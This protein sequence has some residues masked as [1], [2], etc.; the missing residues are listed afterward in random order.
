MIK[1]FERILNFRYVLAISVI[2][3][4][5]SSLIFIIVGAVKSFEGI[6]SFF[7]TGF[8]TDEN[9]RPGLKL[10]EGLDAFMFSLIFM[11]FGLGI[12]RLFL[13]S[14][15]ADINVPAWLQIDDLK[16]LKVL[17]WE[18]I[19]VTLVIFSINPIVSGEALSWEILIFPVFIL[20]LSIAL[21]L[22]RGK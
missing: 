6:I 21:F 10:L 14:K 13:F 11:I 4:L 18:T 16:G 3:L 17:L 8:Q 5:L 19:L 2:F 15:S 12:A 20:I 22:M 7:H 1:I 9:I